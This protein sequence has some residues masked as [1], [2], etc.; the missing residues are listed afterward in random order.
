MIAVQCVITSGVFRWKVTEG[1][2]NSH[3][4]RVV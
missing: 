1:R 3:I 2:W 4:C